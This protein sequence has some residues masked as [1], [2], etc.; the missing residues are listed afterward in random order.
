MTQR[1]WE[2]ERE[3]A[4][5]FLAEKKS[6]RPLANSGDAKRP[7]GGGVPVGGGVGMER[8]DFCREKL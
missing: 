5:V 4:V 8:S 1:C 6:I 7:G 3:S 2:E